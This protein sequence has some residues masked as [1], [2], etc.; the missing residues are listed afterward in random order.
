VRSLIWRLYA[1][2]T[3]SRTTPTPWRRLLPYSG[4]VLEPDF[5][6]L[7]RYRAEQCRLHQAAEV[8]LKVAAASGSFFG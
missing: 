5:N 4:F 7:A 6:R 3:D 8:F 2:L 1:D